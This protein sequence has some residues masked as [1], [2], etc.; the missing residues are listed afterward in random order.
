MPYQFSIK[1]MKKYLSSIVT[2]AGSIALLPISV[3]ANTADFYFERGDKRLD[4]GDNIGAIADFSRVLESQ[5]NNDAAYHNRGI[6]KSNQREFESAIS[7]FTRAIN[8]DPEFAPSYQSRGEAKAL[9]ENCSSA[10]SDFTTSMKLD[11]K[12]H[13]SYVWRAHCYNNMELY[14]NAY[15]DALKSTSM[16]NVSG[17][18]YVELAVAAANLNKHTEAISAYTKTIQYEKHL[19]WAY[20]FRGTAYEQINDMGNAC[21]DWR[22]ASKLG[23]EDES[24]KKNLQK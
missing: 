1:R 15:K 7:D 22:T 21:R 24:L 13:H 11:P 4:N 6:A 20:K 10:I 16:P 12:N 17:D 5:P 14:S 18:N 8:I 9:L 23:D 2:A 3:L 19:A